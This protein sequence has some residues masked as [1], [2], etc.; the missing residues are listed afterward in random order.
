VATRERAVDRGRQRGLRVIQ[1]IGREIRLARR[2]LGLSLEDVARAGGISASTLSR[3][4]RG[5]V[6][7][8]SVVLLA[9]LCE[10]VGLELSGRAFP[11]GPP[12]RDARHAV[13]LSR[14]R[15]R[16]H[17]IVRW[18]TEV[19]L[20]DPGD[21]RAWDGMI[22]GSGWRYGVEAELNPVDG[23]ALIR[24][25]TLKKR[26]GGVDGVILLLPDTRQ[27]RQFRREFATLLA[28][29]FPIRGS[30][31]LERLG[32]GLDPGGSAIVVI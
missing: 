3:I 18:S 9:S 28:T 2:S 12:I 29:D 7:T 24:R 15:V 26:D 16:V 14:L 6:R 11:G 22:T 13:L 10:V 32:R 21:Q 23:Q 17:S 31:A 19:P 20:P 25:L 5:Q 27:A 4:E 1:T 30:V 8:V